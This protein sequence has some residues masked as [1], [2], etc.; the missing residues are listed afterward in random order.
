MSNTAVPGAHPE[1]RTEAALIRMEAITRWFPGVV[2]NREVNLSVRAGSFHAVIGENGAGKSTL[3][4]I[5][6]GRYRP[7]SGRIFLQGTDVTGA[8][9]SPAATRMM[10][11]LTVM[12]VS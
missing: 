10:P 9:Q 4:N 12:I 8:L 3:L 1:K 2:A 11:P 6:Y 5:L 7:D